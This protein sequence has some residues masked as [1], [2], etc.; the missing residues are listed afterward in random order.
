[1]T[2]DD[3]SMIIETLKSATPWAVFG[4]MTIVTKLCT[5]I[6]LIAG[7]VAIIAAVMRAGGPKSGLLTALGWIALGFG[8]LGALYSGFNTYVAAQMT[9]TTRLVILL[10]SIVEA[11][12]CFLA[13]VIVWFIAAG[14][15]ARKR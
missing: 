9:N 5:A 2:T 7:V 4:G 14:N 10:P 15:G 13:G 3:T 11:V 12:Y 6:A 8:L 1:M